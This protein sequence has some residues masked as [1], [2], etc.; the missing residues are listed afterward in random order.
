MKSPSWPSLTVLSVILMLPA[1]SAAQSRTSAGL[2]GSVVTESDFPIA[3]AEVTV[4]YEPTGATKRGLTREDGEFLILLLP[5]GGP[6]TVTVRAIG[7]APERIENVQLRVGETGD[8]TITL[9]SE[10]IEVQGVDVTVG[11]AEIFDTEQVGPLTR[12]S[13]RILTA[14]PLASRDVMAMAVLSPLVTTTES[15]GFSIGGQNDRYNAVLVDGVLAKDMF[16][17]A[18][19]G[20]P[21]GQAGARLIPLDAVAQYEVMVAPYDVRLTGFAGGLMNAVTR[22]GTNDWRVRTSA[23]LRN[24]ALI[25]DLSLPTGSVEANGTNQAL[26]ALSV[27]GPIVR[28][29]AHLFLAGEFERRREPPPGFNLFRDSPELSRLTQENAAEV[30]AILQD[31]YGID[32]G[33]VGPYSLTRETGNL[34][35]RLD[36]NLQGTGRLTFR[37]ILAYGKKDDA[38][39]RAPFGGYELVEC[40]PAQIAEQPDILAILRGRGESGL[41]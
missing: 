6:F 5:V 21:G 24:E 3:G 15:G 32:A 13:E 12:L 19:G 39:N 25:G 7:Y 38:P 9:R 34:F 41:Q 29:R 40:Q 16:G 11:R 28:D 1:S 31:E 17:L 36:W 33:E 23:S 10:A 8:L 4:L 20:A 22:S 18:S 37:H 2:R 35:G 14:L 30:D 27:G 26:L